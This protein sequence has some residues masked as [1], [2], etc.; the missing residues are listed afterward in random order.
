MK[1][2]EFEAFREGVAGVYAFYGREVSDFALD[3][4]WRALQ[5]FDLAAVT[6]AFGRHLVNPD[7]GQYLP[8]PA[9]IVRMMGGTTE[10]SALQAWA[11]VDWAVRCVGCY[12]SLT[13]DDP[14]VQRVIADMGGWVALCAGSDEE[15]PFV[16]RD[17][18]HRYRGYRTR[19]EVPSYPG[20]LVGRIEADNG[21]RGFRAT[22]P[23]VL[24]GD[25]IRAMAVLRAGHDGPLVGATPLRL[26]VGSRG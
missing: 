10:D 9:D 4:W 21:A 17:F 23:P 7:S 16:A 26:V 24:I 12:R 15:W 13:F 20:H 5:Q 25:E 19:S 18:Q 3:V 22:E 2:E 1:R 6:D 11:K 14:L 8:K